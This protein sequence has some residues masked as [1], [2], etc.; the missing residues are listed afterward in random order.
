MIIHVSFLE[1]LFVLVKQIGPVGLIGLHLL[2]KVRQIWEHFNHGSVGWLNDKVNETDLTLR[3]IRRLAV[4]ELTHWELMLLLK[5]P[6]LK[7][8]HEEQVTP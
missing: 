1:P 4:I 2:L 8:L 3:D 5:I 7:E 6:L